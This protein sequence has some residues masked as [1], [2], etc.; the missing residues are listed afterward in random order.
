M[1]IVF[2]DADLKQAIDGACKG[3]LFNQGQVYVPVPIS[4]S[5]RK[6]AEWI[7]ISHL[8]DT[9]EHVS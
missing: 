7:A 8:K 5:G 9:F 4:L 3:I 6:H 2:D 1:N